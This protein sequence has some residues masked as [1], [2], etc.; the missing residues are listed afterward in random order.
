MDYWQDRTSAAFKELANKRLRVVEKKVKRYYAVAMRSVIN[1][2]QSTYEKILESM[3][4]GQK[5]SPADLYKLDKY[6]QLQAQTKKQLRQVGG[7]LISLY[8]SAFEALYKNVYNSLAIKGA[9]S[10]STL[11]SDAIKEIINSVWCADGMS[12]SDRVWN[13][14]AKLQQTLEDGLV[15]TI[16]TGKK[17][18]EL[19]KTLQEQFNV[20]YHRASTLVRTETAHI[21]TQAAQQRYRDYGITKVQFWADPDERTCP[22]CKKMHKK[23][24]PVDAAVPLPLHPNCRCCLVPIIEDKEGITVNIDD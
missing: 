9:A 12:W 4:E 2:F 6:W 11:N 14:M 24:F 10:F 8:S 20:S 5:P 15:Q 16:V 3:N 17:S 1:S 13:D 7:K 22:I 18:T 21:E 23:I 19:K